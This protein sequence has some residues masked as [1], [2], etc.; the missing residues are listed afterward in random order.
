MLGYDGRYSV[1]YRY[2]IEGRT[3]QGEPIYRLDHVCPVLPSSVDAIIL[4]RCSHGCKGRNQEVSFCS[5][6]F[7]PLGNFEASTPNGSTGKAKYRRLGPE[8][9]LQRHITLHCTLVGSPLGPL[10]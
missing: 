7:R 10:W 5:H 4:R 3:D 9:F 1:P 8:P 6:S 2:L